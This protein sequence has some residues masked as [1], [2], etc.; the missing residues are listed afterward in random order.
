MYNTVWH[1]GNQLI[2]QVN[3]LIIIL[4]NTILPVSLEN[5][6]CYCIGL[7]R[8]CSKTVFL[9]L[10]FQWTPTGPVIYAFG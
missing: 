9:H 5:V 4:I 6:I 7:E 1:K 2:N 3:A 8:S 10:K